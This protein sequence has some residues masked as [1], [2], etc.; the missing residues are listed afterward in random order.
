MYKKILVPLDGSHRS[1]KILPHVEELAK[2]Y[3]SKVIFLRVVRYPQLNAYSGM[4][5]GAYQINCEEIA[6]SA[7]SQL[8]LLAGEFR[9][10]GIDAEVRVTAGPT[11]REIVDMAVSKNVDLITMSS[12]GRSGLSRV[13][14]GS[15]AA[16]VLHQVDR[17]MLMIR[18]LGLK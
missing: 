4:E 16:G 15:V 10:K 14:Y 7:V 11:V 8:N 5:P 18:S 12:H 9:E 1:E 6:E 3:G 13:F 2:R 17:P